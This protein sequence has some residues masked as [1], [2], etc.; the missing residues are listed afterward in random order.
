MN[1]EKEQWIQEVMG[2]ARGRTDAPG[3]PYLH[4]RILAAI[5]AAGQKILPAPVR[6]KW[7]LAAAAA[8]C[9]L[10]L[11]NVMGMSRHRQQAPGTADG[12]GQVVQ[13]YG[14]GSELY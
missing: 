4:T 6:P 13:E 9:M 2:A 10:V 12:I 7:I 11:V 3:N 1:H 8:F 14:M 5:D